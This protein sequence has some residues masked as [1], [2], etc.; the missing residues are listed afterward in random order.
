MPHFF[1]IN[2]YLERFGKCVSHQSTRVGKVKL[3]I[4]ANCFSVKVWF[5]IRAITKTNFFR[6]ETQIIFSQYISQQSP[7]DNESIFIP[8]KIKLFRSLDLFRFQYLQARKNNIDW[9]I[10]C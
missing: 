3:K 7:S 2:P 1:N 9:L 6:T 8:F 10:L 5:S 4:V